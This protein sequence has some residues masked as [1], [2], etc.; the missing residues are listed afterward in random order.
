MA[1]ETAEIPKFTDLAIFYL[2][3]DIQSSESRKFPPCEIKLHRY[4]GRETMTNVRDERKNNKSFV[5][6]DTQQENVVNFY[7]FLFQRHA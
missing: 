1:M 5:A 4:K 6:C 3:H 2:I 7:I